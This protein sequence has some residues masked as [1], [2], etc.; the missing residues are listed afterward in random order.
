MKVSHHVYKFFVIQSKTG[1][2]FNMVDLCD[3]SDHLVI[4][5]TDPVHSLSFLT[6]IFHTDHDF[7]SLFPF[8]DKFRD[9]L[10]RVLKISAHTN[11]TVSICLFHTVNRRSG[12]TEVFCIKNS[13]NVFIIG[14]Q[15]ADQ[16]LRIVFGMIVNK[17][18][19]I[20]II[21]EVA[22]HYFCNCF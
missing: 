15:S 6:G 22:L 11:H 12:L 9:H 20:V 17:Q 18:N 10:Y 16:R 7:I 1:K 5:T 19:L 21:T 2:L 3:L 14:T 13:L 4:Q 8:S